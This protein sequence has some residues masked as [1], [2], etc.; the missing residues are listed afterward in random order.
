MADYQVAFGGRFQLGR[1][2]GGAR[3]HVEAQHQAVAVDEG[4]ATE[5]RFNLVTGDRVEAKAGFL[6]QL[7]LPLLDKAAGRHDQTSFEVAADQQFLDQ[8]ARHDG[9]ARPGVVC[10]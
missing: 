8:Q 6:G 3:G 9:F 1:Q 10:E 5:R 4:V 2:L 7:V